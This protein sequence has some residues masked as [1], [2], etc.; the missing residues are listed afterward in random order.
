MEV[1]CINRT[2]QNHF[3]AGQKTR[4]MSRSRYQTNSETAYPNVFLAITLFHALKSK[5]L[6]VC[7]RAPVV[8]QQY[9]LPVMSSTVNLKLPAR[10]TLRYVTLR[11]FCYQCV[12]IH[13]HG[14]WSGTGRYPTNPLNWWRHWAEGRY[15]SKALNCL[16]YRRQQDAAYGPEGAHWKP[17]LQA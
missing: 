5:Q 14:R 6:Q 3:G 13:R 9:K 4:I 17:Q 1:F 8:A 7:S 15:R 11:C 16:N 2:L 10:L 12:V